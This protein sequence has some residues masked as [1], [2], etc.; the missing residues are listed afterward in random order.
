MKVREISLLGGKLDAQLKFCYK[1]I[2]NRNP[3]PPQ[4]SSTLITRSRA[5]FLPLQRFCG[6]AKV[7]LSDTG[8]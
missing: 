6:L 3:L 5:F 4:P 8:S 2:K 7:S 1:N